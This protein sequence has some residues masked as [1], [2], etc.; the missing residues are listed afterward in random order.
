MGEY[1]ETIILDNDEIFDSDEMYENDQIFDS[2][3]IFDSD[4][5]S[6]GDKIE[7]TP[8]NV[9]RIFFWYSLVI[10]AVIGVIFYSSIDSIFLGSGIGGYIGVLLGRWRGYFTLLKF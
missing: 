8:I 1:T 10:G 7:I 5:M 2:D 4:E 6:D 3:G 9:K